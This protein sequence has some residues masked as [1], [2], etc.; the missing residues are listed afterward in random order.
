MLTQTG[1]KGTTKT[2]RFKNFEQCYKIEIENE[3]VYNLSTI[4]CASELLQLN[5]LL[6]QL[7]QTSTNLKVLLKKKNIFF[8]YWIVLTKFKLLFNKYRGKQDMQ[9]CMFKQCT[10][11]FREIANLVFKGY[12][13]FNDYNQYWYRRKRYFTLLNNVQLLNQQLQKQQ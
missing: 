12:V 10:T 5:K 1:Y 13:I 3:K 11:P 7:A 8:P 9:N 4:I 2:E 6:A